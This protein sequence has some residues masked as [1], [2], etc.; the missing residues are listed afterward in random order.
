MPSLRWRC[1]GRTWLQFPDTCAAADVRP[2]AGDNRQHRER[3]RSPEV[4]YFIPPSLPRVYL[5]VDYHAWVFYLLLE[6]STYYL[7][8]E[9]RDW[10]KSIIIFIIIIIII[11]ISTN[12]KIPLLNIGIPQYNPFKL[13]L[14]CSVT[15]GFSVFRHLYWVSSLPSVLVRPFGDQCFIF[16]VQQLSVLLRR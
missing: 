9:L 11:N 1:C 2:F 10:P 3:E 15:I 5:L 13:M 6:M 7:E 14:F 12:N 8:D 16:D 4:I